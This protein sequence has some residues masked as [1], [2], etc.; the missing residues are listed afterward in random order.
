MNELSFAYPDH[1][2]SAMWFLLLLLVPFVLVRQWQKKWGIS[3]TA[4]M[5][6]LFGVPVR[7]RI[8]PFSGLCKALGII[9]L[10]VAMA[11]PQT[12]AELDYD[13]ADAR[14]IML[15]LD[16]S[17]S[18]QQRDFR[19]RTATVTRMKAL[20]FV[21]EDFAKKRQGD[22]LGL[23]VFGSVAM[24][25][26]P[27]TLDLKF[28][29][30]MLEQAY[31]GMV[32]RETSI[33]NGLALGL[34]RIESSESKEKVVILL[35]D[36]ADTASTIEPLVAAKM[37]KTLG[38]KVYAIGMGG[39]PGMFQRGVDFGLLKKISEQTGGS[40]YRARSGA[41]LED[42]YAEIDKL[43][44]TEIDADPV[45]RYTDLAKLYLVFGFFLVAF[46]VLW[47]SFLGRRGVG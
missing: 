17:G 41:E 31:P 28:F 10:I 36:G 33:G 32:G 23:V 29:S 34:K 40:F 13:K 6:S 15:V 11:R 47:E 42:V 18:M 43:E 9:L 22:R 21:V 30:R 46:G 16:T 39:S 25:Q 2:A 20:K 37:A 1:F 4:S 12:V 38:V 5:A 27:L 8:I 7:L 26:V 3:Y 45:F 14:D 35:S 24:T 44:T 19:W